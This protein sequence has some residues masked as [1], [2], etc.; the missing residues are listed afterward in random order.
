MTEPTRAV[1]HPLALAPAARFAAF[2]LPPLF[3]QYAVSPDGVRVVDPNWQLRPV[4][5]W[6][7]LWLCLRRLTPHKVIE[8]PPLSGVRPEPFIPPYSL[9]R[10]PQTPEPRVSCSRILCDYNCTLLSTGR[11]DVGTHIHTFPR[12]S[13]STPPRSFRHLRRAPHPRFRLIRQAV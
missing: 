11:N 9:R 6:L 12:C 2:L 8:D 4:R 5:P 1:P 10:I 13:L 7:S 3:M